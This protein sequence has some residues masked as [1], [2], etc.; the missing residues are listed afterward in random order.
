MDITLQEETVH[1]GLQSQIEIFES[2]VG[3]FSVVMKY[4]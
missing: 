1:A 2:K 4:V 3:W